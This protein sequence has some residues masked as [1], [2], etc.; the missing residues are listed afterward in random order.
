MQYQLFSQRLLGGQETRTRVGVIHRQAGLAEGLQVLLQQSGEY[1]AQLLS[2]ECC[3]AQIREL[4]LHMVVAELCLSSVEMAR[5]LKGT[6]PVIFLRDDSAVDELVLELL[7]LDVFGLAHLSQSEDLLRGCASLLK[8]RSY[9]APYPE[10]K[11]LRALAGLGSQ[12]RLTPLE[13]SL[14]AT[15]SEPQPVPPIAE[16]P[17]V[18]SEGVRHHLVRIQRKLTGKHR[19]QPVQ[20]TKSQEE[21]SMAAAPPGRNEANHL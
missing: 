2:P 10:A 17:M 11:V 1:Q 14:L 6:I 18:L 19:H 12:L 20:P 13:L 4:Q 16:E 3:A 15:L 21:E 9:L 8:G 7:D 5:D